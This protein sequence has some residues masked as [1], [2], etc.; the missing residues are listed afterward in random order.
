VRI[1]RLICQVFPGKTPTNVCAGRLDFGSV[2]TQ[3]FGTAGA[4]NVSSKAFVA[5]RQFVERI[6]AAKT[7][8]VRAELVNSYLEGR[9]SLDSPDIEKYQMHEIL[10][11]TA[12]GKFHAEVWGG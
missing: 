9:F 12:F 7:V 11:Y 4:M 2:E 8:L 1:R 10:A 3:Y 6:L 5:D